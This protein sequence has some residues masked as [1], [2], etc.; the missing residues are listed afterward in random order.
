MCC[1]VLC[2]WN[3]DLFV[4]ISMPLS[5]NS[6][7]TSYEWMK[8]KKAKKIWT[9]SICETCFLLSK[10]PHFMTVHS[11]GRRTRKK[12][13]TQTNLNERSERFIECRMIL[14]VQA[15]QKKRMFLIINTFHLSAWMPM[16]LC[17]RTSRHN[18]KKC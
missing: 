4:L 10:T 2:I 9:Y 18:K 3:F 11:T 1:A 5:S 12:T 15:S 13:H 8:R 7:K 6:H 16:Y 17:I 14:T